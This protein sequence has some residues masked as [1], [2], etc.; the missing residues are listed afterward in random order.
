MS[1]IVMSSFSQLSEFLVFQATTLHIGSS[2]MPKTQNGLNNS[3]LAKIP[4]QIPNR[5]HQTKL[6][7]TMNLLK[8]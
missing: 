8:L 7:L 6:L 5:Q 3:S 2:G 4:V 1:H